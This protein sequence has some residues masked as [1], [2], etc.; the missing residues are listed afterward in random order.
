VFGVSICSRQF[1]GEEKKSVRWRSNTKGAD[2][3]DAATIGAQKHWNSIMR[4]PA[5][6][7]S[8]YRLKVTHAVGK[9]RNKNSINA[10]FYAR[11]AIERFTPVR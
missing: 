7:I 4:N 6:K 5:E 11:I 8:A 3:L 1:K 2:A 10:F 9:K